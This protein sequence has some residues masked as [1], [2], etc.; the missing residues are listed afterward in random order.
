LRCESLIE[1][2]FVLYLMSDRNV[3]DIETQLLVDFERETG[4]TKQFVDIRAT[5]RNGRVKLFPV[6]PS[7][8]DKSGRLKADVELMR[9]QV[10][11]VIAHDIEIIDELIVTEGLVY[12]ACAILRARDLRNSRDMHRMCELLEG[13]SQ[14]VQVFRLLQ[15]FGDLGLGWNAM[16]N[17]ID[18]GVIEHDCPDP[19]NMRLTHISWL[20]TNL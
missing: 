15:E 18:E 11:G 6:R 1:A 8:L 5:Y 3:V 7:T 19:T 17:L 4:P 16:W 9:D 14:P 12:R 2:N 10:L 13:R 20:R